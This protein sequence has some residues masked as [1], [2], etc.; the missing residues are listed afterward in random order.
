MSR[1]CTAHCQIEVPTFWV[2]PCPVPPKQARLASV[3]PLPKPFGE[4]W[5]HWNPPD[6]PLIA[7]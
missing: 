2:M 5:V 6:D 3:T 7:P 1:P 4:T